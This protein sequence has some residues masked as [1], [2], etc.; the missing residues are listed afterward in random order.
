MGIGQRRRALCQA[1][2][3]TLEG[4]RCSS[5]SDQEDRGVVQARGDLR[6]P[7]RDGVLESE[8]T[9]DG[10]GTRAL[11]EAPSEQVQKATQ[12]WVF[13]ATDPRL[14]E[15]DRRGGGRP[16]GLERVVSRSRHEQIDLG[17]A[18]LSAAILEDRRHHLAHAVG[19][20]NRQLS[21]HGLTGHHEAR[22]GLVGDPASTD[23]AD[24]FTDPAVDAVGSDDGEPTSP[25]AHDRR[26]ELG[27][28]EP[29]RLRDRGDALL[30]TEALGQSSQLALEV[31]DVRT[32]VLGLEKAP[33]LVE[34]WVLRLGDQRPIGARIETKSVG[35]GVV[36]AL[37]EEDEGPVG[38]LAS[39]LLPAAPGD[40]HEQQASGSSANHRRAQAS[41]APV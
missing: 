28:G 15:E 2:H 18:A 29:T 5:V 10:H 4:Q 6:P 33:D 26:A 40:G 1:G 9:L 20:E 38:E 22:E 39:S 27:Q 37:V 8:H 32:K 17:P 36:R 16:E 30:D 24:G 23:A 25:V 31:L 13:E 19:L 12:E 3:S 35:S 34:A 7:R 21:W 14:C 11:S 41:F